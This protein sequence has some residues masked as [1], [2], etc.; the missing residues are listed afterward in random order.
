[1]LSTLSVNTLFIPAHAFKSQL[2]RPLLFLLK[3]PVEVLSAS[4]NPPPFLTLWSFQN[5]LISYALCLLGY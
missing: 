3:S 2:R 4:L 1:M 5:S